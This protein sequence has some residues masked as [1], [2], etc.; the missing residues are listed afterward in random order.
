MPAKCA[1]MLLECVVNSTTS[2][3]EMIDMPPQLQSA[4][5]A[6]FSCHESLTSSSLSTP[7]PPSDARGVDLAEWLLRDMHSADMRSRFEWAASQWGVVQ[8][9]VTGSQCRSAR[10]V[11]PTGSDRLRAHIL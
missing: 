1:A 2:P 11:S 4:V 9:L 7:P 6:L 8:G 5:S 10:I 3:A